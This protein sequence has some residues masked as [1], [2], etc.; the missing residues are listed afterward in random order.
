[1]GRG[2][3][4]RTLGSAHSVATFT[5]TQQ[6]P[7]VQPAPG[8][9]DQLAAQ[10]L[11]GFPAGLQRHERFD[12]LPRDRV[13]LADDPGLGDR[14]VLHQQAFHLEWTDQVAR[15]LDHVV[16]A[17]DE[18][19]VTI[20]IAAGHV[21]GEIPGA[22]AELELLDYDFH[23]F[24]DRLT[25]QDSVIYRTTG[26]YR[27]AMA[28]PKPSRLGPVPGSMTVSELPAPRRTVEEAAERLEAMGQPFMFF[29][30]T[31]TSRGSLI[32]HRYDGHYGLIRP[33][34]ERD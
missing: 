27:L 4:C 33:A 24:T 34:D 1:M 17:D 11:A 32:C 31:H 16:S 6:V 3:V 8:E 28:H 15:G 21:A 26:G 18:P 5:A 2:A 12:D 29:I 19:V 7:E 30:D 13:R 23:L 25:G 10:F 9:C 14:W 22:A 20:G